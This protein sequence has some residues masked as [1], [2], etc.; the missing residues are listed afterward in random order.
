MAKQHGDQLYYT[1]RMGPRSQPFANNSRTFDQLKFSGGFRLIRKAE[2]SN[3]IMEYY[4][5]FGHIRLMEDNFNHEFDNYKR[6]AA[7]IID[8]AVLRQQET[9]GGEIVP[10]NTNP[11]LMTY[12][13]NMLKE[14]AFHTLQ[15]A[16][17]RRSKILMLEH[18]A[19]TASGLMDHL[20]KQYR[21]P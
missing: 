10:G 14:L 3:R 12:D 13:G 16:G 15:M 8:P 21:L 11:A 9:A 7:K 18:L 1:A 19:T 2:S 5:L 6:L 17:S 4:N 20:K